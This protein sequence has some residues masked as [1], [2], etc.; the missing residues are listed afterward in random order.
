MADSSDFRLSRYPG[1]WRGGEPRV[2]AVHAEDELWRY[3]NL[4]GANVLTVAYEGGGLNSAFNAIAKAANVSD[5]SSFQ[6]LL[7]NLSELSEQQPLVVY[8]HRADRLL[9]DVGPALIHVM[10]GWERF[11]RL[12][13]GVHPMYLV[14]E[15]GPRATVH[16]AFYP[17]GKVDWL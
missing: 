1:S 2:F 7:E 8:L 14:V 3:F 11:V 10:T 15:I 4:D 17:G 9:A 5:N 6:A 16:A 12:G 13:A